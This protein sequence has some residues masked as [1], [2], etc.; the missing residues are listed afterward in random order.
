MNT[1]KTAALMIGLMVLLVFVGGALWG[2]NGMFLFFGI[3]MT[4]VAT[5]ADLFDLAKYP[6]YRCR[7]RFKTR[8]LSNR[9]LSTY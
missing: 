8:R 1:I 3:G 7:Q 2:R 9:H 6:S 5:G 4:A